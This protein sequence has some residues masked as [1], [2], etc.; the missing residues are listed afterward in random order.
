MLT[1]AKSQKKKYFTAGLCRRIPLIENPQQLGCTEPHQNIN[2]PACGGAVFWL[3]CFETGN[4]SALTEAWFIG[5]QHCRL[6]Y[7]LFTVGNMHLSSF[8][9]EKAMPLFL[10]PIKEC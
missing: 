7:F 10:S 6:L 9:R 3:F 5:D 4:G 1:N 2:A 8:E